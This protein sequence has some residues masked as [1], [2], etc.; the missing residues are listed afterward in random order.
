MSFIVIVGACE[1]S[2]ACSTCHVI[3]QVSMFGT[4]LF[5]D[6]ENLAYTILTH[7]SQLMQNDVGCV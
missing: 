5:L 3:V 7:N 2:C 4:C 6:E 1:G